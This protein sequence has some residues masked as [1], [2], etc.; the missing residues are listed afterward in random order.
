MIIIILGLECP[1]HFTRSENDSA[2][3]HSDVNGRMIVS[4][5]VPFKSLKCIYE[6][7]FVHIFIVI[8]FQQ[9]KNM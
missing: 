8:T 5:L 6:K 2:I 4:V 3:Y 1:E 9:I 7:C